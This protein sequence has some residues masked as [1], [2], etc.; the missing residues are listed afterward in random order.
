MSVCLCSMSISTIFFF[1][2]LFSALK[3]SRPNRRGVQ[4]VHD[5]RSS[6]FLSSFFHLDSACEHFATRFPWC[7]RLFGCSPALVKQEYI[8]VVHIRKEHS[9]VENMLLE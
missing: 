1:I 4:N 8:V 5:N 7:G 3:M 9:R 6:F 2:L